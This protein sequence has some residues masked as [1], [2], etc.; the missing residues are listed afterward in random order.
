VRAPWL[1]SGYLKDEPASERLWRGG[2]LHTGD[3][4]SLNNDGCLQIT[5]RIKDLVKTG[6]EWISCLDVEEAIFQHP[7]VQEVA[8]IGLPHE[9]WGERPAAIVVILEEERGRVSAEDIRE[10]VLAHAE[11]GMLPKYAVPDQVFFC[12]A[13]ARTSVG[14]VNK[15]QLREQY[16]A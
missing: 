12:E 5:D 15:R 16:G 14:K 4:A 10:F 3:V 11:R 6:G 13:L 8:V 7:A 2:Y 9:K 1:T